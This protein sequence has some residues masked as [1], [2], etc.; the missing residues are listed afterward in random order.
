MV[1][2][3][4]HINADGDVHMV[5]VGSKQST[6]RVAIAE[7]FVTMDDDLR[8]KVFA[9]D[10]RKGDVLATVRIAAIM[11]AKRTSELIPLCHPLTLSGISVDVEQ[12]GTGARIEVRVETSGQ[13]GVEME[14]MTAASIAAVTM[15]DMVKSVSKGVTIGPIQLVHK[16]GGKSGEWNR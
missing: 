16:S 10:T 5:S 15:Y 9:G 1:E 12:I 13:T 7:A 2:D 3:L 11:A 14:A 4:T 6:D 8:T